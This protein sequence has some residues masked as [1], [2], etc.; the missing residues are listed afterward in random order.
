MKWRISDYLEID[1]RKYYMD[2]TDTLDCGLETM[3]FDIREDGSIDWSGLYTEHY[4][5]IDEAKEGHE[6]IKNNLIEYI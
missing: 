1:G 5:T 6:R 3:V 2:T 4:K